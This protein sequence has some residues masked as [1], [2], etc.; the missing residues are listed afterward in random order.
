VKPKTAIFALSTVAMVTSLTLVLVGEAAPPK[1]EAPDLAEDLGDARA[2]VRHEAAVR[3]AQLDSTAPLA[4][5][6][7]KTVDDPDYT[8]KLWACAALGKSG[9]PRAFSKLVERLGDPEIHVRYR[10]AEGLGFL[11]DPR[12]V[13]PLLAVMRERSWYEGAYALDALRRIQP[14]VR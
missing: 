10:A 1:K 3:A 7:L 9:D 11:K 6:L 2:A 4:E 8:V 12:A 5:A 14:G 13:E